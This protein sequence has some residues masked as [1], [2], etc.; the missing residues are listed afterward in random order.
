[1]SQLQK[2]LFVLTAYVVSF[3]LTSLH[4]S[5]S[6]GAHSAKRSLC[7]GNTC[8]IVICHIPPGNPANAHTISVSTNAWAAHKSHGDYKGSCRIST[9]TPTP[10]V[11]TTPSPVPTEP[12]PSPTAVETT[13][14]HPTPQLTAECTAGGPYVHVQCSGQPAAVKMNS[15]NLSTESAPISYKWI[16]TCPDGVFDDSSIESPTLSFTSYS[17]DGVPVACG[18]ALTVQYSN[19]TSS[20][21][22]SSVTVDQCKRDCA[23]I[24]NG[25]AAYDSC[26]VCGGDGSTCECVE[27]HIQGEINELSSK[28]SLQC[29]NLDKVMKKYAKTPCGRNSREIAQLRSVMGRVCKLGNAKIRSIPTLKGNCNGVCTLCNNELTK[30][31]LKDLTAK[32][33]KLSRRAADLHAQCFA[34]GICRRAAADCRLTG[35]A[36]ANQHRAA[37]SEIKKIYGNAVESLSKIPSST[38]D[39]TK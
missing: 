6:Y 19:E 26:G 21:C 34:R 31:N 14:P 18:V 3:L 36:I 39:C 4:A 1:M 12:L 38:F 25:K 7:R 9:P 29:G 13:T 16:T 27:I 37:E 32:L 8:K 11:T 35:L 28:F 23:G 33:Y 24:I 15:Q 10:A 22:T 5:P 30:H 17:G 2:R 20:S